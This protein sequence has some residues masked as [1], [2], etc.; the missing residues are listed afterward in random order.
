[1]IIFRNEDLVEIEGI[2]F[3]YVQEL[4]PDRDPT[5]QIKQFMP[6]T[7]YTKHATSK[8][9]PYGKGPFCK[10]SINSEWA[11]RSGV[12]ALISGKELLYIG[13]CVDLRKRYNMGYGNIS[14]K[15]CFRG[16]QPTNCKI[17]T[18]VISEYTKGNKV[19][20]YFH[21]TGEHKLVESRLLISLKPPY[22]GSV[23]RSFST[24]AIDEVSVQCVNV[25]EVPT[26]TSK[27]DDRSGNSCKNAVK[28]S[29]ISDHDIDMI[30]RN[31]VSHEGETFYKKRGEP[32]KYSVI[33]NRIKLSTTNRDIS[34]GVF[35]QA[36]EYMP[37]EKT[38]PIQH[39]QAPSYLFAILTDRRIL[40]PI[41]LS[42]S[43]R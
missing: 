33:A 7:R 1:M 41:N 5:G 19:A 3:H 38:T 23:M 25:D 27:H 39:L 6:Q 31:I 11:G 32:F 30:W 20:L 29:N 10:F 22:N 4:N 16:G 9:N 36:L 15:N 28:R 18:M 34:K 37:L 35:Q 17:N 13:E 43:I 8:I 40:Q 14:P 42:D 12:Y 24:S 21:E 26:K 2:Q